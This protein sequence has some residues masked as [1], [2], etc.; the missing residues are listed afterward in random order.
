VL[1]AGAD[2]MP[3]VYSVMNIVGLI[4]LGIATLLTIVSGIEYFVKNPT[5]LKG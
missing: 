3:G 2:L 5:V 4:L 1:L